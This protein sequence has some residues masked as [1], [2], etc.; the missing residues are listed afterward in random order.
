LIEIKGPVG[1]KDLSLEDGLAA[2]EQ[3]LLQRRYDTEMAA[4]GIQNITRM[5]IAV[6]GKT[7]RVKEVL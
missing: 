5:A 2:A 7:V 3:Q 6:R 1:L 4:Q